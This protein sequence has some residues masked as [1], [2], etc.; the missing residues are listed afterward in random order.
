MENPNY[1]VNP[2]AKAMIA[3]ELKKVLV[4]DGTE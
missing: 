2:N 4:E 3:E 1:P